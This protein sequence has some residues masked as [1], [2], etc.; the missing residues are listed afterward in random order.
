MI[1]YKLLNQVPLG[2]HEAEID[3]EDLPFGGEG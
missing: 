3:P 1:D 2:R